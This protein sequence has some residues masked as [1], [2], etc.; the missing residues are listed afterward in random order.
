MK[1]TQDK[2]KQTL[3]R[4]VFEH[5]IPNVEPFA[6]FMLGASWGL[7]ENQLIPKMMQFGLVCEDGMIDLDVMEKAIMHGFKAAKDK[8]PIPVLGHT[9]TFKPDDWVTFKRMF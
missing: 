9:F 1:F 8:F 4:F 3:Q 2:F 7:M 6:Q 5:V